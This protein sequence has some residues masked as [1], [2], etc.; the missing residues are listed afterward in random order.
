MKKVIHLVEDLKVGGLERVIA[1]I[2]THC[3]KDRFKMEVWCVTSGGAIADE[4][5]LKGIP[6]RIIGIRSYY[7]PINIIRFAILLRKAIPDIVHTHGYF[8]G[9][10]GRIACLLVGIRPVFHHVHS[11]YTG[12]SNRNHF[13]EKVLSNTTA[14]VICCSRAVAEFI[15]KREHINPK[16]IAVVYNGIE[17]PLVTITDINKI[18]DEFKIKSTDKLVGTVASLTENK[19]HAVLLNAIP[20]IVVNHPTVRFLFVGDGPCRAALVD[21]VKRLGIEERV[22][23]TGIRSDIGA[24]ISIMDVFVLPSRDR[25]GLPIS[26]IEVMALSKPV[27]VS[28]IGGIPEAVSDGVTGILVQPK[29]P[30][31]LSAAIT[32]LLDD[33]KKAEQFGKAGYHE[34]ESKFTVNNMINNLQTLYTSFSGK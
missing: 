22:I 12:F 6:V 26:I 21:Q 7:N 24:L 10:M 13:I 2:V 29:N 3:N 1:A 19:G 32:A 23:F 20:E 14:K 15:T 8:A 33:P 16:R 28:R 11:T 25:E 34:F 5:I 18:K 4:L 30:D 31:R 27:V 17:K 9:T